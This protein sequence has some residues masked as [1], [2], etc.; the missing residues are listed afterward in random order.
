MKYVTLIYKSE[1]FPVP[2]SAGNSL[3]YHL[4]MILPYIWS[5]S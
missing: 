5:F 2:F 3:Y 1:K 4:L